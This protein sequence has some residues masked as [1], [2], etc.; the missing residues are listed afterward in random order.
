MANKNNKSVEELLEEAIVN[1]DV[2]YKIPGNWV[3]VN[4]GSVLDIEGGTQPP[5]SQFV[6]EE[7]QGYIRLYQIRDFSSENYKTY[8][9]EN[10][11]LRLMTEDDIMLARY[12]ASIG[13]VFIGKNGAY[14][15]AL[16]K[17]IFDKN[18][19]ETNY[20]FWFLKS[21]L[22]QNKL[23]FM[24]RTAVAGFNK[25]D[26]KD[27]E[28]PLPP[29]KEQKRIVE[30][31][32]SLFE[33]LDKSLE[34]IQEA[35]DGFATRKAAILEK[36]FRGEL[37][38]QWRAS[39]IY[40]IFGDKYLRK[41]LEERNFIYN[42]LVEE[43]KKLGLK[44]PT[45]I[46]QSDIECEVI[47]KCP[48]WIYT[49]LKNIVYDFRYG[50]S[51]KSEYHFEG[52]PVIR[53]PN[54]VDGYI[55]KEDLKYL[56]EEVVDYNNKVSAG[57]ILIVRSNGSP[58]LVGKTSLVT[59]NEND[60]AFASYLI[61]IRPCL[62]EP[63]FLYYSLNSLSVKEQFFSKSKS[64]SGINN[65]NTEELGNSIIALPP[66]EEQKE[67]V[68]ILDKLLEEEDKI[69]E[70]TQLEE[71]IELIKKSILA[72]AFRG[73]LGTNRAEEDSAEELLREILGK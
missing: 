60:F 39:H 20:L 45:K 6:F 34:L 44:K 40:D 12:G 21:D 64:T 36:A 11:K 23:G 70:L 32:E 9:Q 58:L 51:A 46:H 47:E 10:K 63:K 62:I 13:K 50:T 68:R 1:E 15:V 59:E 4:F 26:L 67:I 42:K 16:A 29:K 24:S 28:V 61:R 3:C 7:K 19:F 30:R 52:K 57:D 27:F 38:K 49:K 41:I 25:N 31:I 69:E 65:I 18:L 35:R 54:L 43:N 73:E 66:L 56:N 5:K 22:F 53:I 55:S 14:N 72:K 17:L 48:T 37:T 8:V 2:P 71:Q 33:K